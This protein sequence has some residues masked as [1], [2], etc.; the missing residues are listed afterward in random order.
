MS[1]APSPQGTA[2]RASTASQSAGVSSAMVRSSQPGSPVYPVRFTM[3]SIP[4]SVLIENVNAGASSSPSRSSACGPCT[5]TRPYSAER[6][7][8]S[9]P[10]T[11]R[12]FSQAK[13][14]SLFPAFTIRR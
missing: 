2:P 6:S 8:T 1:R 13:A 3:H 11:S 7:V 14:A 12:S 9:V 5:A 4:S 10:R